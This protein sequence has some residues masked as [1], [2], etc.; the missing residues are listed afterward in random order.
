[1]FSAVLFQ[2]N[3]YDLTQLQKSQALYIFPVD[4]R[5]RIVFVFK[6]LHNQKGYTGVAAIVFTENNGD[7]NGK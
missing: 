5:Q 6:S 2:K 4:E 7:W 1:M 3:L